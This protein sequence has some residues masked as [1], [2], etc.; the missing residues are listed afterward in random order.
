MLIYRPLLFEG[1]LR[2]KTPPFSSVPFKSGMIHQLAF[3]EKKRPA[4]GLKAFDLCEEKGQTRSNCGSASAVATGLRN[5]RASRQE[6]W[7]GTV[8]K[9]RN[10]KKLR[11]YF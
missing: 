6:E 1:L 11:V 9:S 2:N 4:L 7:S 10:F 3:S 5:R 8:G